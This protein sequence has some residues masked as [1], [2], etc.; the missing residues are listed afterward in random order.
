MQ[1]PQ[2]AQFAPDP[3]LPRGQGDLEAL[4]RLKEAIKSNQ[5]E[6]FRATPRL[7]ALASLYQG[8]LGTLQPPSSL[9]VSL[10]PEQMHSNPPEKAAAVTMSSGGGFET[11][12]PSG[13]SG[14]TRVQGASLAA[15]GPRP[16]IS[17]NNMVRLSLLCDCIPLSCVLDVS[18]RRSL[19]PLG[20]KRVIRLTGVRR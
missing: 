12:A 3:A 18:R 14:D 17:S 4:E 9:S 7:D 5:H 15:G 20:T 8:S 19:P 10:H 6:I 16:G 1:H 13:F 11:V 2:Q